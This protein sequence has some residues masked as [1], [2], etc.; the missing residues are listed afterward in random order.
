MRVGEKGKQKPDRGAPALLVVCGAA[1]V[2]PGL[3]YWKCCTPY[4]GHQHDVSVELGVVAVPQSGGRFACCFVFSSLRVGAEALVW[5]Q[6][7]SLCF[8]LQSPSHISYS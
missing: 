1:C 4:S 3:S 7:N 2:A 6:R 5:R 8:F